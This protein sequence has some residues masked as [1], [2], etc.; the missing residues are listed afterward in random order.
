MEIKQEKKNDQKKE[1]KLTEST[2]DVW[3]R[4]RQNIRIMMIDGKE[5]VVF[6]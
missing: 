2:K 4:N 5:A 6:M 3:T 1:Q